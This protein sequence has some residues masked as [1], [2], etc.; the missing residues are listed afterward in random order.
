MDELTMNKRILI[1]EDDPA[2]SRSFSLFLRHKG[3]EV[4]CA[5]NGMDG[6][7]QLQG[8][9]FDL[10]VTDV[11]MPK[12]N[13]LQFLEA[14]KELRP[15]LPV[16]MVTGFTDL[17]TAITAM[18][19]GAMDFVTK[20]FRY[21]Q[22]ENTIAGILANGGK[23]EKRF[24]H[25]DLHARLEHKV[26][27][28][29][30]LYSIHEALESLSNTDE[31]FAALTDLA[32]DITEARSSAFF[33]ADHESETYYL[34][35]G[36]TQGAAESRPQAFR[37]D[38]SIQERLAVERSPLVWQGDEILD[39]YRD[40]VPADRQPTAL[41]LA[42]LYVRNESFGILAV[43]DKASDPQR[44][45]QTDVNFINVLLKK[46]S[47]Q[48][49]NN[50]LY[51]TI[52]S[53]LVDTLRSLVSTLE[54]KDPYTERHSNRVTRV[55][56]L[57]A[58]EVGCSAE[59]LDTLQFA[60]VLHDIGKIGISDAILQKKGRLTKEEYEIIKTHPVIGERIL[61]PLGMLPH[62]KAI[63]RHHHERWDGKGYPDGLAGRDIPF[64]VRIVSLADAYDAM[65]SNRV[66]RNK[67]SHEV[68]AAEVERNAWYQFDG[69]LVKAFF[70]LCE[71][72]KDHP[73]PVLSIEG[74]QINTVIP[75]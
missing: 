66:Y 59:E 51:E 29:S 68:A 23:T 49:E 26:H 33:I 56:V 30:V 69:N 14:I 8:Q 35:H 62:E 24:D 6:M 38:R 57:L 22:L 64:L 47:L 42:P 39:F 50:A 67:L 48:I 70:R 11:M 45:T 5:V 10:V 46:A 53:N 28:L 52:Y 54:A 21:E 18:K 19:N 40:A 74:I 60:G 4:E 31:L 7:T 43:E 3:Y 55:A 15:N 20:P 36:F 17:Q 32:C 75:E 61:E 44:F 1:V 41:V 65:T 71:K 13:G 27:E 2:I 37:L 25:A 34:K 12:M 73:D 63:I 72:Q 9:E 58:R 16:I